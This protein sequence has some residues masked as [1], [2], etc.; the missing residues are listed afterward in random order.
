[1][2]S[3]RLSIGQQIVAVCGLLVGVSVTGLGQGTSEDLSQAS[4]EQLGQIKVYAASKHSQ[5]QGD[6]PASVTIIT[7]DEIQ[8]HGYRT[9][10]SVLQMVR[11][12]F[13]TYDRN[14]SSV[15]IRGFGRPGDYN[16][17]ILVLV[18]GHRL[19]DAVYDEA[20]IGTEFVLDIDLIARIEVIRGPSSSLY[21]SNALFAVV[22]IVTR[23]GTDLNGLEVSGE[24]AS[25]NTYKGRISYGGTLRDTEFLASGTF[26]GS[27]G[28]NRLS[29]PSFDGSGS[30]V[31]N[32]A[33]DD[34]AGNGFATLTIHDLTIEGAYGTREKGIPTGA[35]E[36]VVG[37]PRTRTTDNHGYIDVSYRKLL[38]GSWDL[39]ARTYYDRYT[40]HGIYAYPSETDPGQV[41]PNLDYADGQWWGTEVQVT[42]NLFPRNRVTVGGEYR[43]N[44]RQNQWN[45]YLNPYA[46]ILNDR[47]NSFVFA[48]F[49]QDEIT[50]TKALSLNVGFR[51]D[52][53]NTYA[54]SFDPRAAL[55]Y[56]PWQQTAI[57]VIYGE[58]FRVPNV[59][60]QYYYWPF[61][62]NTGPLKPERSRSTE[63]VWE[64]GISK[65]VW[66]TASGFHVDTHD[67][68][69]EVPR[70]DGSFLF[71][72]SGN[73]NSTGAEFEIR[74]QLP[75][76]LDGAISYSFQETKDENTGRLLS[77]APRNLVKVSLSQPFLHR[78]MFATLDAHYRGRV[79]PLDSRPVSP[80]TVMNFTLLSRNIGGHVDFS[81]SAYNIFDKKYFDPP[82]S[83]N[84]QL[85]IQQ[86]GRSVRLK[87]TWH[88]GAQ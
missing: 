38:A 34:Q 79:N 66:L 85:P 28:A 29:F 7:A 44:F 23:R 26:Y 83:S 46:P 67:L 22:N 14:Y 58:S 64:Q 31:S 10:A 37:D 73:A 12:F 81:V 4:I 49:L 41:T 52:Y 21:G 88:S 51:D 74:G 36:T 35:Y 15:G 54:S 16:T 77:D 6:A 87:L 63:V 3:G 57:K 9:L 30:V 50:L 39:L 43:N 86:D 19:N 42:R 18:D 17:R 80:F 61:P 82:S 55:I 62:V 75:A 45:F 76:G 2:K 71:E 20:M 13:V 1:M 72:N 5:S 32:H 60:E 11:G 70:S 27:R 56:R 78:K 25:F 33:D 24:A 59:Y 8:K 69:T 48:S 68:I 65:R 53:Y 40:Y 47:R 84:F